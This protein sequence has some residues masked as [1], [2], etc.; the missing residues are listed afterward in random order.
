[1]QRK[2]W[3]DGVVF[4]RVLKQFGQRNRREEE[5]MRIVGLNLNVESHAASV[6]DVGQSPVP[7][8]RLEFLGE[9]DERPAAAFEDVSVGGAQGRMNQGATSLRCSM[10][11]A[12]ALRLLNRKCGSTSRPR[13]S[14]SVWRRACSRRALRNRSLSQSRSRNTVS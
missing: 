3:H 11:C 4:Q 2:F 1:M 6:A 8:E 5:P 13:L 12:S 10:R 7:L 14:S 9:P